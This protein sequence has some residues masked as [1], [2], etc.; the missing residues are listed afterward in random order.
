VR[1]RYSGEWRT[2]LGDAS[3]P[4]EEIVV[5][6]KIQNVKTRQDADAGPP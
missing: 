5:P 3:E 4:P 1:G 6:G 2:F